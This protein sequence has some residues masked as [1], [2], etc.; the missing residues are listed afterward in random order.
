ILDALPVPDI[1]LDFA[2]TLP[3]TLHFTNASD[4][5]NPVYNWT[6]G[7]VNTDSTQVFFA[8]DYY[9]YLTDSSGCTTA[10]HV[11]VEVPPVL[12]GMG[13]GCQKACDTLLP[14]TVFT[15]ITA[16]NWAWIHNGS[17]VLSGNNTT[18]IPLPI[19]TPDGDYR[20]AIGG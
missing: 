13:M 2:C 5:A 20:L 6:T 18:D 11:N 8:G 19:Q 14:A 1:T 10:N 9:L 17:V 3:A 12:A 15:H 4:Y 16:D 7:I